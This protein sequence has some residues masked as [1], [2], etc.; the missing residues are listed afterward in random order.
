M[1]SLLLPAGRIDAQETVLTYEIGDCRVSILSDGGHDAT[2][3]LL[4]GATPEILDKYLPSG[5]FLL[6]TQ[7][8]LLRFP[9]KTVLIDAG[10]GK[11]LSANLQSLKVTEEQVQV[12]LLTH[13]HNDHIGG[14]LRDGKKAFPNAELY[15]AQAEYDYWTGANAR[16]D[17]ARRVLDT[18]KDRLHLFVPREPET[19]TPDLIPGVKPVAAY[20]HT[21]GHTAFLLESAGRKLLVWGDVAHAMDVQMPRPEVALTFDVNPQ[22]AVETR[23]KI[24]EYV[25][26][27]KIT[28]SGAHIKLPAIGNVNTGK[29]E[30]YAFTPLCTCEAI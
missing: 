22:Q 29:D 21:P 26:K 5:S 1:A 14:L 7:S 18:Y 13:M 25:S 28:I 16:G 2:P 19:E 9:D 27:N 4:K 23:K 6:E 24:L 11:N 20:G 17:N 8:F 10:T 12:I 15:V 30:G 3:S